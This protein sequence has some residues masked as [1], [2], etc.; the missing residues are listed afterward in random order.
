MDCSFTN[1]H[2]GKSAHSSVKMCDVL[3][4]VVGDEMYEKNY[5]GEDLDLYVSLFSS[6]RW[7]VM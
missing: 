7:L 4:L 6:L 1:K 3:S 2:I 5:K